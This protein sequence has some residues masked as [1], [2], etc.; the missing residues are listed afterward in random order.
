MS[1]I[2]TTASDFLRGEPQLAYGLGKIT[3]SIA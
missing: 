2:V 3:L 1:P